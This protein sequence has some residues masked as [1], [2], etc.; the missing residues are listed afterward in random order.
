M[1]VWF[2]S[3]LK[4]AAGPLLR[5][6]AAD[7][8]DGDALITDGSGNLAFGAATPAA[9]EHAHD[10]LSGLAGDDH[11]QYLLLAGRVGGQSVAGKLAAEELQVGGEAHFGTETDN[12]NSGTSQTIDWQAGNKQRLTLTGNATLTFTAPRG[13][14]SLMLKLIQDG[15]GGRTVTWPAAVKWPGG[16]AP[17]LTATAGA[18][19]IVALYFDGTGYYGQ[20]AKAFA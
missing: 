3:Y 19:D 14:C 16:A 6:P 7:G 8:V 20:C 9:H 12:G 18:L 2:V 17:A 1:P 15:T 5:V 4:R 11:P 13:A 10:S